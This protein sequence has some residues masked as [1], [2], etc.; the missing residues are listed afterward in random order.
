MTHVLD[1]HPF[2]LVE[3]PKIKASRAI[4]KRSLLSEES[5]MRMLG[6]VRPTPEPARPAVQ[7]GARRRTRRRR[8]PPQLEKRA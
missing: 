7:R 8:H 5:A 4:D 1:V 6:W 2:A 3:I